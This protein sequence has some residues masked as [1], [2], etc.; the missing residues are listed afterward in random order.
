M[1][2]SKR[3]TSVAANDISSVSRKGGLNSA[4]PSDFYICHPLRLPSQLAG[5]GAGELAPLAPRDVGV[6]AIIAA[7]LF[8]RPGEREVTKAIQSRA[9]KVRRTPL[10]DLTLLGI[11]VQSAGG[12]TGAEDVGGQTLQGGTVGAVDGPAAIGVG[13]QSEGMGRFSRKPS[14]CLLPFFPRWS[15]PS[16]W[17]SSG[18][19]RRPEAHSSRCGEDSRLLP[20]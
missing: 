20:F 16:C 14:S 8:S 3:T 18:S 17:D 7:H 1:A 15:F 13:A 10:V 12:E 5:A 2:V 4:H 11:V 9:S 19:G 6:M